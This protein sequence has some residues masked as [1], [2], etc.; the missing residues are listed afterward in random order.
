VKRKEKEP[1][2]PQEKINCID[3]ER[4]KKNIKL[5]PIFFSKPLDKYKLI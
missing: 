4:G 2:R 1:L 5:T 3:K